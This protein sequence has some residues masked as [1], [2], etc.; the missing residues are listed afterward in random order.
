MEA[1]IS[2][3][4]L[5]KETTEFGRRLFKACLEDLLEAG[6]AHEIIVVDNGC[7]GDVRDMAKGMLNTVFDEKGV[8]WAWTI[9]ES[10]DF[11][12][13]RNRALKVTSKDCTH[14]HWI[15]TD[16]CY[17]ADTLQ[18]LK[19]MCQDMSFSAI[20]SYFTH[21]MIDPTQWQQTENKINLYKIVP[22][23]RWEL[24]VH[25]HLVGY[26][27]ER[28]GWAN[29]EYHHYG[30]IR[31]QWV[32]ALK[33]LRYDVWHKGHANHYREYFDEGWD[34]IMDYYS[35]E[36]TPNQCLIDR[37]PYC[38]KYIGKYTE[39]FK[40]NVLYPWDKSGLLWEEWLKN[41]VGGWEFWE[42]WEEKR[43]ELGSWK[44][45]I[46]WACKEY[47]LEEVNGTNNGKDQSEEGS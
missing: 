29:V 36:R 28:V 6:Y 2:V 26:D 12:A 43:K 7:S 20:M 24:P 27:K 1:K 13:L 15:D 18:K 3:H 11:A 38:Q 31:P 25:E 44:A 10:K 5:A 9:D 39:G 37:K 16:E 34:K 47:G 22:G 41:E 35:D 33:W 14:F 45:T 23:L 40:R 19:D 46:G 21:F 17:P 30:Y 8:G 4:I 32:Q 42:Q